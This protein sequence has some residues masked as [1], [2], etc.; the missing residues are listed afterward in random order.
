M[1]ERV[2]SLCDTELVVNIFFIVRN[3]EV[4]SGAEVYSMIQE[5]K[6]WILL[7]L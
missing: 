6:L 2:L 5:A 1:N 3:G 7:V 4:M